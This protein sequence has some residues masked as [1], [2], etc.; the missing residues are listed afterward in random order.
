MR[1]YT[2]KIKKLHENPA[3]IFRF[4]F[5][6]SIFLF[7][8]SGDSD[9]AYMMNETADFTGF[10][11]AQ[12]PVTSPGKYAFLYDDIPDSIQGIVK[13]VQ[14]VLV[15]PEQI[16][17]QHLQVS[18]RKFDSEVNIKTVEKMLSKI[19]DKENLS[20]TI[21]RKFENKLVGICTHFALLTCSILRHKGIPARSRGGF[22]TPKTAVNYHDHW[23]V[24]YW[25]SEEERWVRIDPE[26]N[27]FLINLWNIRYDPFDLPGTEFLSGADAWRLCRSG[28]KSPRQFGIMGSTW[29]G[30]W[31]FILNEIVLDFLALNKHEMLPWDEIGLSEKGMKNLTGEE[32]TLLDKLAGMLETGKEIFP[33]MRELF[34]TNERFHR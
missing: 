20:F 16:K 30:G 14:N 28:K 23:I 19:I 2:A 26:K 13:A 15:H 7:C 25:N 11:T 4:I 9:P 12:S 29:I 21:N 5:V 1:R 31:D 22:E 34:L 17:G 3:I 32:K 10:Y 27:R 8:S 24:E 18:R 33:E 6:I